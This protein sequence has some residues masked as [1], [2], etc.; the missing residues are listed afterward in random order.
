MYNLKCSN[1]FTKVP[2]VLAFFKVLGKVSLTCKTNSYMQIS[3]IKKQVLRSQD[4]LAQVNY[5]YFKIEK[6]V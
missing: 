4:T 6:W 1:P 2:K 5:S 3:V